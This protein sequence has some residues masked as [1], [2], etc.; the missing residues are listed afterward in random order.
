MKSHKLNI[1]IFS[2]NKN[3]YSE[4]FIQA[5][6]NHLKGDIYYYFGYG[7]QI[8]LEGQTRLMPY[9]LHLVLRLYSRFLKKRSTYIWQQLI[10]YSL[11]INK[12]DAILVEYGTHAN[13]LKYVLKN[14]KLPVIAHYHGFD[15]S[16][17][18]VIEAC[19]QYKDVFQI[20]DK[21]IV[22]SKKMEKAILALG[23][24]SEKMMYNV[25]GPKKQFEILK[26]TFKKKQFLSV[27]RFTDKK[28]P[29][30]TILAFHQVIN[31][32]PDA[33]LLMAGDGTLLNMCK[34]L[35][36]HLN[37]E[38]NVLFLGVI[39]PQD[40]SR[41]LGESLAYVQH[42]IVAENGD[43]EGTPLSILE[44]SASG[45]PVLS[46]IH[47]GIPDVIIDGR[48]GLL[49]PEHDVDGMAEKMMLLLDN[50]ELAMELGKNG[51][52][53]IKNNFSLKRHI[54]ALDDLIE[55]VTKRHE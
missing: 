45:L 18:D 19:N 47:A 44:A 28:A 8:Q 11:K 48:T 13:H 15:A 21:I 36:K 31:K 1:A 4:T 2:P 33:K 38:N 22:V 37:L 6:K 41:F 49:V 30:Y 9:Y 20:S 34:N 42:S 46:T 40:F 52:V 55:K 14:S 17:Y 32:Y 3:P 50:K 5:H 35:V 43:S 53:R 29:Y 10:L 12:I 25:Y 24:S 27:G 39:T 16:R 23:L 54:D 7:N 51:K 26:P